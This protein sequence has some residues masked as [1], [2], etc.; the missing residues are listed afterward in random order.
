MT[1]RTR[2]L[3]ASIGQ[4]PRL[5][6]AGI[7]RFAARRW[8]RP[9]FGAVA[10]A[11]VACGSDST[12]SPAGTS[13]SATNCTGSCASAGQALTTGDVQQV[14]A[15]AVNEARARS[16]Q[17]TIAV[18][19]RVGNVLAVYRMGPASARSVLIASSTDAAGN[20]L[21]S[22]GLEGIR[23]PVS[24]P[25][26]TALNIDDQAAI[27]KAL[28]GAY[29]S[30]EGN[31]FSTRT[32]SQIIGKHFD[33]WEQG[34]PSGPLFGVQFSQ[35][36]C[37][38]FSTRFN[39]TAPNSGPH[40]APLGLSADPGGFP[41]YKGGT[42]VGGVGVLAD[43]LYSIDNSTVLTSIDDDEA[44]AYAATYGFGA[45]VNIRADQITINGLTLRFS[46]I[47]YNQL[48]ADPS[49]APAFTTLDA[50]TGAL[51]STTNYAN[52]VIHQ[53][54]AFAQPASGVRADAGT[55]F[56]GQNA[57]IFVDD[58]NTPRYTP[59]G[60]TDGSNALSGAEVTQ[61][62][63]SGLAVASQARS[64][65][66]MPSGS[67]ARVT[68]AVVDTNGTILGMVAS[69]D[70]PIFG[71]DVSVQKARSAAFF[72]SASAGSYIESLPDTRYLTTDTAG[73]HVQ[74]LPPAGY[75]SALQT[76]LAEPAALTDGVI[77]YSDRAIGNLSRPLFP[78]GIDGSPPGPLSKP[79]PGWSPFSTG[80]QLDLS[81][82]A[83][84]QHV[85][86]V[87][88]A[89]LPDAVP[90]CTG[91]DLASD[92]SAATRTVTD[93]RLGNGLQIFAGSVPIFRGSTLVGAI[94]VSGD[95]VD[96]DDLVAFLGLANAST[97]L[98]GAVGNA[99]VSRRADTL[100]PQ[101]GRL[102]YVECPQAPFNN[103][104]AEDVCAGL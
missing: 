9:L 37:S 27:S 88:G 48:A 12:L 26:L 76:F 73:I 17:A 71:A 81:I 67:A 51:V 18:V 49:Q 22:G 15:Q 65:I 87:A 32:A 53:G 21:I 39:N 80:L 30:S 42:V 28:T 94:G 79:A 75:V 89:G 98:N 74:S 50:G 58:T 36:A 5:S 59:T 82:N 91:V 33:P 13:Q 45:P 93:F 62:L 102:K 61:I 16:L 77:A 14:L 1:K 101:G 40:R 44:I 25:G 95:G 34:Q 100:T 69:Q 60:G 90:G 2:Q 38:D 97:A 86:H 41:L 20:P 54:V 7:A 6:R 72:S 52:A 103:S 57:Y 99:P 29:L 47:D 19:D 63:S 10:L 55:V 104:T 56:P 35:L 66:R 46:D 24:A 83:I 3:A 68:I 31:A 43:G 78:D 23:L 84:L 85:L 70:A 4:R 92:L 11:L 96:Q 64:Q 8:R